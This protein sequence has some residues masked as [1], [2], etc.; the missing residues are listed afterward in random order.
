MRTHLFTTVLSVLVLAGLSSPAS[1]QD[2]I[3]AEGGLGLSSLE[4][5][6]TV[7]LV[8]ESDSWPGWMRATT[9]RYIHNGR[10]V[11][12]ETISEIGLLVGPSWQVGRGLGHFRAAVGAGG[13]ATHFSD[14][15]PGHPTGDFWTLAVP[16]SGSLFWQPAPVVGAGLTLFGN[17]NRYH[18]LGGAILTVQLGRIR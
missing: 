16:V 1:A 6:A 7:A 13:A 9:L 10:I 8:V 4:V 11:G 5:G 15:Q 14:A 2:R 18:N 12:S 3:W 17:V